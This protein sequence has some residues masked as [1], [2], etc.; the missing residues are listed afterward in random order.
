LV[1]ALALALAAPALLAQRAA[2]A[3]AFDAD[4]LLRIDALLQGEIDAGHHAGAS[5]V[6][7]HGGQQVAERAFGLS[8]LERHRPMRVDTIVRIY[9]MSKV[10]TALAALQLYERGL[11]QLDD[12]IDKF[13]PELRDPVVFVGGTIEAPQT[14]PCARP[15]TVRMLLNHTAGLTYD[16][17]T[18]PIQEL[19][20]RADLWS[21]A[22]LDDF[23]HRVAALPLL[24]QPGTA[25]HYSIADDVL[26][27]LIERAAGQPLPEYE[28]EHLTGPLGMNDTGFDVPADKRDRLAGLC[29]SDAGKLKP[30]APILGS[31]DQ[32][33]AGF[34][35]GGG[36]MFSTLRDYSRLLRM[37]LGG[38]ELD[39]VRVLGRKTLELGSLNSLGAG[40]GGPRPGDGW[41]LFSAV[42]VDCAA[43]SEL[44][45]PGMLYWSGAATTHFFVDPRE[46]L[47]AVLLCQ[48]LPYDQ[49]RLIPRFRTAV[50]QA[51]R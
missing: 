18:T 50:Y 1:W 28:R 29:T 42:R 12:R 48:H 41:G 22:S 7:W 21:A 17:Q 51:L 44:G 49:H 25:W 8:D 6:L 37:I 23:V 46:D 45:S 34:P 30:S 19:Y 13:L 4:R 15:I 32:P 26:G 36:G 16:F 31:L 2:V 10:V 20:R 27:A 14:E 39:G 9:S 11:F 35:S 47:I 24:M 33:G 3:P 43:S 38:G 5:Y 40:Q